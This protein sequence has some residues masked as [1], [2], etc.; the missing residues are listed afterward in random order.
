MN[1]LC[2]K[3][4]ANGRKQ[5]KKVLREM[6]SLEKRIADHAK[7]H[8]TALKTRRNETALREAQAQ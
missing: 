5:R 1:T 8:L 3:M 6:K 2:M 7:A 4:A